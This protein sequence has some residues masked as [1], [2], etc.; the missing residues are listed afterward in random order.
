[1]KILT[2]MGAVLLC[3][4]LGV[5]GQSLTEIAKKEKERREKNTE[6]V[7]VVNQGTLEGYER[8]D[9]EDVAPGEDETG[10]G[11]ED[12]TAETQVKNAPEPAADVREREAEFLAER[13]ACSERLKHA[14]AELKQQVALLRKGVILWGEATTTYGGTII[15]DTDGTEE[16]VGAVPGYYRYEQGHV[17]CVMATR[18]RNRYPSAAAE[19]NV[20]EERIDELRAEIGAGCR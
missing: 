6:S 20:I 9:A 8:K 13:A 17:S 3:L 2:V 12:A 14:Q 4:A 5:S 1:M 16:V 19:C 10:S 15:I 11:G 7:T 18:N